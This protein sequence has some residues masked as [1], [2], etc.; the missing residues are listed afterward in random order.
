MVRAEGTS[1]QR[2]EDKIT[3]VQQRQAHS[4]ESTPDKS[5][6]NPVQTSGGESEVLGY[7]NGGTVVET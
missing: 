7:Q 4:C 2:K 1:S 5:M 3:V 6:E